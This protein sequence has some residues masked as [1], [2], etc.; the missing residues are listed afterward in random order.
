MRQAADL[1]ISICLVPT[2]KDSRVLHIPLWLTTCPQ[3]IDD[4]L[5]QEEVEPTWAGRANYL[6]NATNKIRQ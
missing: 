3:K 5:N 4:S 6:R 2:A 1:T